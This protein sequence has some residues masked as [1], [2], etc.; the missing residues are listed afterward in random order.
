[1]R[2]NDL[3]VSNRKIVVQVL[4]RINDGRQALQLVVATDCKTAGINLVF[5]VTAEQRCFLL[6]LHSKLLDVSN[7]SQTIMGI[8]VISMLVISFSWHPGID[9]TVVSACIPCLFLGGSMSWWMVVQEILCKPGT[10]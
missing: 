1:M 4:W 7:L 6:K 3:C 5:V 8:L 10:D 9:N 2:G